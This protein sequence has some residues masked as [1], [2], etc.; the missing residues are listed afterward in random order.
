MIFASLLKAL[1][2]KYEHD[3][4][5]VTVAR[6]IARRFAHFL[7]TADRYISYLHSDIQSTVV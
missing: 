3:P 7:F 4:T 6:D 5:P 2:E 1:G